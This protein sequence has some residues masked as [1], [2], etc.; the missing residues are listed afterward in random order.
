MRSQSLYR[1]S[2]LVS[3]LCSAVYTVVCRLPVPTEGTSTYTAVPLA[4]SLRYRRKR[5]KKL[6]IWVSNSCSVVGISLAFCRQVYTESQG[7]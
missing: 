4:L 1:A 3:Q 6:S 2:N 7:L 5:E